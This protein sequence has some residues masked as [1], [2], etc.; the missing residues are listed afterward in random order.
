MNHSLAHSLAQP[1][2]GD[3][4][5][6][7]FEVANSTI[8]EEDGGKKG[9]FGFT[10]HFMQ[11]TRMIE[12]S[13]HAD[14]E[15]ERDEWIRAYMEVQK[16]LNAEY[17]ASPQLVDGMQGLIFSDNEAKPCKIGL[18]DFDMLKVRC[19]VVF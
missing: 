9:K 17:L 3:L 16:K 2:E 19:H 1:A 18:E 5:L 12:R 7:V 15:R 14:T 10:I 8:R 4:P 11:L 6:N 13:F